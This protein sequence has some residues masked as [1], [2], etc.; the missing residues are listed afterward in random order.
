MMTSTTL[1]SAYA[2][3]FAA[4]REYIWDLDVVEMLADVEVDTYDAF[5]DAKK[6]QKDYAK[7]YTIVHAEGVDNDDESLISA[8]DNFKQ[9]CDSYAEDTEPAYLDLYHVNET[10]PDDVVEDELS[11]SDED[12]DTEEESIEEESIEPESEEIEIEEE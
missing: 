12:I 6:L 7:L 2:E 9:L 4:M 1:Q 5:V 8:C 3:L 10:I 11:K